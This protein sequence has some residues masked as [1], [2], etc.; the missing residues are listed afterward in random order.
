MDQPRIPPTAGYA[1][2]PFRDGYALTFTA[3]AAVVGRL[4]VRLGDKPFETQG[5]AE[6]FLRKYMRKKR[7][8]LQLVAPGVVGGHRVVEVE[9]RYGIVFSDDLNSGTMG[10]PRAE[11]HIWGHADH[12]L[13]ETRAAAELAAGGPRERLRRMD[14]IEPGDPTSH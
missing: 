4:F 8:P 2:V 9:G 6:D 10:D 14:R 12:G 5:S 3:P 7:M 11:Y 13:F 1:T